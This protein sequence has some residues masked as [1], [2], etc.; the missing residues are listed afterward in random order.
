MKRLI[1]CGLVA[2]VMVVSAGVRS[3]RAD[4]IFSF[5]PGALQPAENLLFNDPSL[6]L[7]GTTVQGITNTTATL[8]DIT[9]QELLVGDG[10]QARVSGQ[11][12]TFTY[13]LF[14]AHDPLTMFTEFKA[15]VGVYKTSGQS[16]T[17]TVTVKATDSL[18]NVTTVSYG[19]GGG[20]NFFSVLATDP[21]L[22]RSLELTSTVPLADME[23]IRVGGLTDPERT[24]V[25]EPASLLLFGSG[26]FAIARRLRRR[27]S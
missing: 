11:D 17:G 13:L 9:G 4:I 8:F 16:P 6:T 26:L 2:C 23:Q 15:N 5:D 10:G 27:A 3:A 14:N 19:V 12:G 7:T 20:Q 18:G 1:V 22:L 21:D 25:P 24:P